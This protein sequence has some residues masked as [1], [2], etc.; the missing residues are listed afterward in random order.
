M[1][2]ARGQRVVRKRRE[3]EGR[4]VY[5]QGGIAKQ[6]LSLV[7]DSICCQLGPLNFLLPPDLFDSD[8]NS[9]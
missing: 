9:R 7:S 2:A 1:S 3:E 6:G 4:S 5:V 8:R